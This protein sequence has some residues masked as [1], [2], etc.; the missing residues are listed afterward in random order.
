MTSMDE[1]LSRQF[2]E[3]IRPYINRLNR[4]FENTHS[5]KI[6]LIIDGSTTSNLTKSTLYYMVGQKCKTA[7]ISELTLSQVYAYAN[8]NPRR[9]I[10][11]G[12][13]E[14]GNIFIKIRII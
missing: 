10:S 4:A 11:I 8:A 14:A 6:V 9:L 5:S 1:K 13:R 12:Q 7:Q 2:R 3:I